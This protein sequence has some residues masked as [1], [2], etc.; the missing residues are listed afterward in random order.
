MASSWLFTRKDESVYISRAGQH[1]V[2]VAGPGQTRQHFEFDSDT[3]VERYQRQ[4]A[5]Q[6][7][8]GGWILYAVDR[9]RRGDERSGEAQR[10][11]PNRRLE[12]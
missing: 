11:G 3:A 1:A 10:R 8:A 7:A 5:E 6:M 4:V 2:V 12:S 9:D